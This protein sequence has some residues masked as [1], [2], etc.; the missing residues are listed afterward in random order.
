MTKVVSEPPVLNQV[1]LVVKDLPTSVAFYRRVGLAVAEIPLPEWAPHHATA[2]M[3][4]GV[5]LEIDSLE[6]ARQWDPGWRDRP[7]VGCVLFFGVPSRDEVDRLFSTLTSAGA[8]AQK[9]PEDAFWGA[10]YAI[11]EDPDGNAV[12][13]MS[14]IDPAFRRAPPAPPSEST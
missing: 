2:V 6:F 12:G 13:L 3:P 14:P 7:G 9:P 8:P 10:R 1:N 4:N 11:V 5:R